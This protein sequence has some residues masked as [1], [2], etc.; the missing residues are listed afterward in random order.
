MQRHNTD[1][2]V[3][4]KGSRRSDESYDSQSTAPTSIQ[5]SLRPSSRPS[6][7][8]AATTGS[9]FCSITYDED[10]SPCTSIYERASTETYTSSIA[11]IY[12]E[13]E[14]LDDLEYEVPAYRHDFVESEP[15][16]ST[17]QDF[18]DFF[19]SQRRLCI[20]HDDTT[21]DGNMNLRVDTEVT[22][23]RHKVP[24]T[25]FHLRMQ[26][27]KAREFSLRRY[28]RDSGREVCHSSQ[29][30]AK[31]A[32]ERPGLQRSMS[33]AFASLRMRPEGIRRTNSWGSTKSAKINPKRQDSGYGSDGEDDDFY[34]A[35]DDDVESFMSD[36]SSASVQLPAKTTKLEFSNYAQVDVKR[37]GSKGNKR[38]EFEY[39][40]YTY[41]WKRVSN[42][43]G[44]GKR[45]S[46][47]LVKGESPNV[48]AHIVP[49]MRSPH[50]VRA[51]E[52]AG[53]WVP[54][55]SM[56]ISDEKV[57]SALTDVADVIIATGL[58]ALVDDCIKQRFSPKHKQ[59][60]KMNV[61][62]TQRSIEYVGPKALVDAMF[63]RRGSVEKEREHGHRESPLRRHIV[64]Y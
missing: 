3:R 50:Q 31:P 55:C 41:T 13:P 35:E 60:R 18:A 4:S 26:D 64:A 38:Y 28:C 20:R 11:E 40:G 21:S 59:P 56:W 47:H 6:L 29:R 53:G 24:L 48:I 42:K 16:A 62:L 1:P 43:D 57:L 49:E 58:I 14:D 51:E 10:L 5:E 39:W 9:R 7:Q 52:E 17:P 36:K 27:L 23:G 54:P 44:A 19:P 37:R 61:P 8:H 34:A 25:L 33:S 32:S 46:Y 30:T 2:S 63:R 12:E 45:I 15:R 22:E